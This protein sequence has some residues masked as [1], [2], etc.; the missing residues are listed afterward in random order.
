MVDNSELSN[1][2]LV[3]DYMIDFKIT[4]KFNIY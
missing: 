1:V 2:S 3:L 4:T